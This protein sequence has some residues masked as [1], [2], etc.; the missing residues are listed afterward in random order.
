VSST[1]SEPTDKLL[2]RVDSI[3]EAFWDLARAAC[4]EIERFRPDVLIVLYH[5]GQGALQATR[6][7]WEVRYD[8]PFPPVVAITWG[9][10]KVRPYQR[11]RYNLGC[12]T[13]VAFMEPNDQCGHFLA[14]VAEQPGWQEDLAARV[15][16]ALGADVPPGRVLVLDDFIH[17]GTTWLSILNLID[18]TFPEA[19]AEIMAGDLDGWKL[20]LAKDWLQREHPAVYAQI[21]TDTE[22]LNR[23][24]KERWEQLTSEERVILLHSGQMGEPQDLGRFHDLAD[25]VTGTEDVAPHSLAW[26]PLTPE[27]AV[28]QRLTDYLP[29]E[30]L[31]ALSEI[32]YG[33]IARYVRALAE[34]PAAWEKPYTH[35]YNMKP[36]QLA[37]EP[38][39][40]R[41]A[42][43]RGRLARRDVLALTDHSPYRAT[44]LLKSWADRKFLVRRGRGGGTYYEVRHPYGILAYG[45]LL[46]DPGEEIAEMTVDRIPVTTPFPIEYARSSRG[47]AGAPT[48]VPVPEGC[49]APVQ[50]QILLLRPDLRA[51]AVTHMLYR[52]ETN[53]VGEVDV[54][55]VEEKQQEKNDPVLIKTVDD[56]GGV[57][58]VLTT[59]LQPNLDVVLDADLSV[60]AKAAHLARLAVESVTAETYAAGR[61][62]IRYL[63]DA[64]AHGIETPLTAAYRAAVLR[65]ANDAPDLTTARQSIAQKK[66]LV[67]ED[68]A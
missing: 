14:W 43:R 68:D 26:R 33:R 28:V 4:R 49:G 7:V 15:H 58:H 1:A 60:E 67:L 65:L 36:R 62:G 48:L 39:V 55:Y 56:L 6:A 57:P 32:I 52:R 41:E 22:A 31:L 61:D 63:A 16:D 25:L 44:S 21:E 64:L 30:T 38:L 8:A 20:W 53:R 51:D 66:E 40:L 12:G 19:E 29:V 27:N 45:S 59:W 10:E 2:E 24:Q 50:A 23:E 17:E 34:D 54:Y 46:A 13:F 47:R 42:W 35:S 9:R 18:L 11:L 5:S 3:L 37:A